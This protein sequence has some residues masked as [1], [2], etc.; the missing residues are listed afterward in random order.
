[1]AYPNDCIPAQAVV[2]LANKDVNRLI[3]EVGRFELQTDA[4][5]NVVGKGTLPNVSTVVRTVQAERALP[6]SSLVRPIF[7]N[8]ED[9]CALPGNV[10]QVG[11]TEFQF[12]LQTLRERGPKVCVKTTRTAWPGSYAALV[13]SLKQSMREVVGADTRANFL[14][15]GGV[16]LVADSTAT[17]AQ[18]F[19]GDINTVG[20]NFANRT[21]DSPLSF[22]GLEYLATYMREVLGVTPYDGEGD[23]GSMMFIGSQDQ[24]QR[25][26]DE[27]DIHEDLRALTT[28]RYKMG[29]DTI[30]GYK[31]KGP[32]HGIAF[33][34]DRRPLRANTLTAVANGD[35]D[36]RTGL[37]NNTGATYMVPVLIEP[38]VAT[39]TTKGVSA[40]PNPTWANA[41]Y[42]IGFLFGDRGFKRLTPES[43]KTEGFDFNSPISNM[44]LK[45]KL[46][47][48]ADCNFW[49]DFGQHRYEVERAFQPIEP[50]AV[51]AIIYNR[52]TG[53]LG[54]VA[55]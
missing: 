5:M 7:V 22:R 45:F 31:F 9:A 46:L 21:P 15:N 29:E 36:P 44:G 28:G 18:A 41:T 4:Y 53:N 55:C 43:Y 16:K 42:E 3:G 14:D 40:R 33:G 49:E 39:A 50:H 8:S 51:A 13:N 27:L 37:V 35:V 54:L 52:C 24:I 23:E 48:D 30:S 1:M 6:G 38:Y 19:S 20:A 47:D 11:S 10:T 34:I 32:Y 12:Q 25:F 2:D 17:F 26:R